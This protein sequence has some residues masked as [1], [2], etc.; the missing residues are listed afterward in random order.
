MRL[1]EGMID[2]RSD[3]SLLLMWS[4]SHQLA[5][6]LESINRNTHGAI[7]YQSLCS[8]HVI[9]TSVAKAEHEID[10][11]IGRISELVREI[12]RRVEIRKGEERPTVRILEALHIA[13]HYY[14]PQLPIKAFHK[15]QVRNRLL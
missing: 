10:S 13:L 14:L 11:T 7:R 1:L 9:A 8:F 2:T 3:M 6:L 4:K 5:W 15:L 12:V